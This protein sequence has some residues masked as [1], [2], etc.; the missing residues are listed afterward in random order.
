LRQLHAELFKDASLD[1]VLT[2]FHATHTAALM[3]KLLATADLDTRLG[4]SRTAS[5]KLAS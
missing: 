1:P 4:L 3:E 5:E 2:P